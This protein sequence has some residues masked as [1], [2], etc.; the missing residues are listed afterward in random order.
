MNPRSKM[1]NRLAEK[2]WDGEMRDL[3]VV[4]PIA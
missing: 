4:S 2:V 3:I 1:R